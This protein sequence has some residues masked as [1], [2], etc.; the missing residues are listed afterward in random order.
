MNIHG[1]EEEN[2]EA[3]QKTTQQTIESHASNELKPK[4]RAQGGVWILASDFP[5]AF[6][7]IIIYHNMSC[8]KHTEVYH[9]SWHD[10]HH[11]FIANE[12]DIFIKMTLDEDFFKKYKEENGFEASMTISQVIAKQ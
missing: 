5:H 8:Y 9:D 3:D 11:P 6:Q 1:T 10:P 2:K 4:Q 12:K 7:N